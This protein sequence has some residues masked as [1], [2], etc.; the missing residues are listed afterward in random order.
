MRT[1]DD[2]AEPGDR[3]PA[4][5]RGRPG[6]SVVILPYCTTESVGQANSRA[7]TSLRLMLPARSAH[8]GRRRNFEAQRFSSSAIA[9]ADQA[10]E[11]MC[12]PSAP[13]A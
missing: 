4:L 10:R 8:V 5:E 6:L 3:A 12:W 13:S 2:A 7:N 1:G 9:A 11:L